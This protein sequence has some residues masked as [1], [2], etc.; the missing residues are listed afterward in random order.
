MGYTLDMI[1][2]IKTWFTKNKEK[3]VLNI[4]VDYIHCSL[5]SYLIEDLRSQISK[6]LA[7]KFIKEHGETLNKNIVNDPDFADAVYNAIVLRKAK[8]FI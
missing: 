6:I 1:T 7:D 2:N 3:D 8:D 5:Q 4:Q